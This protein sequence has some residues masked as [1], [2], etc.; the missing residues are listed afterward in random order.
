MARGKK[1]KQTTE[2]SYKNPNG[3]GSVYKLSGDRR[4]PY[5][6]RVS[7]G[8]DLI[9]VNGKPK[10][11]QK[12]FTVGYA[13]TYE[14][15]S[16]MLAD[17]HKKKNAGLIVLNSRP[18]FKQIYES[19]LPKRLE[20][21]SLSS[22]NA[23]GAAFKSLKPI[24]DTPIDQIKAVTM[25]NI[26]DDAYQK[27]NKKDS[28]SN[29]KMVC[30]MVFESAF[31]ND[32]VIKNYATFIKIPKTE[33][34][35]NRVPFSND[36]ILMLKDNQD[37]PYADTILIM[38]YT[39]IRVNELLKTKTCDV[40][41]EERYFITGS[42]TD[43]GKNRIIPI[44]NQI[45]EIII[46]Y[47]NT[48]NEYLI[49]DSSGNKMTVNHYREYEFNRVMNELGMTHLPHDCRHTYASITDSL[50][51]NKVTRQIILGHKGS[52]ITESIYTHKNTQELI[53]ESDKT[54]ANSC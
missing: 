50:G 29:I 28:L 40:N 27:G 44:P 53:S 51:M 15:G 31:Q 47:Y 6:V 12:Y 34:V 4:R 33:K 3:Y 35:I 30:N 22:K 2:R 45:K 17:Y 7:D 43:A 13:E 46:K 38:I 14:E 49:N 48:D 41:L 23:Y 36:E 32:L 20:G 26:I 10:K 21:K 42:K 5:M 16:I 8:W 25:Q 9:E 37:L 39:G 1:K 54:W 19:V 52:D 24:H 18:T 11:K